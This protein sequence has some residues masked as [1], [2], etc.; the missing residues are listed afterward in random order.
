MIL[1]LLFRLRSI[2]YTH[3]ALSGSALSAGQ[4]VLC[5]D[6][7]DPSLIPDQE[8]TLIVHHTETRGISRH[9]V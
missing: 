2:A 4:C 9:R 1:A 7:L 5:R 3:L 8:W 6:E